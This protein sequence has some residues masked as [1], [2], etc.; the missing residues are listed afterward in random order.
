[1]QADAEGQDVSPHTKITRL[2]SMEWLLRSLQAAVILGVP[3]ALKQGPLHFSDLAQAVKADP[4][5][6]RRVLQALAAHGIFS[7][8]V[9][10]GVYS[11]NSVSICLISDHPTK[12][13]A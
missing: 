2:L 8:D 3:D 6:L 11:H 12:V 5:R 4:D 9:R 1:M 13:A 7:E 10:T